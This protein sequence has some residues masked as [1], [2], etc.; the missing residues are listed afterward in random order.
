MKYATEVIDLLAAYPG[1]EFQMAHIVRHVTGG[2]E[3]NPA[4]RNAVRIG[5]FR[6]LREL[7]DSGHVHQLKHSQ[8]RSTYAWRRPLLHEGGENCYPICNNTGRTIAP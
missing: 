5:I 2:R 8:T 3:V 1:R 6:V 7:T 4:Q